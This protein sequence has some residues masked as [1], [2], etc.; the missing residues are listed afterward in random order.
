MGTSDD[1][2]LEL[3]PVLRSDSLQ[4]LLLGGRYALERALG[5]GGAG[6]VYRA[7][8]QPLGRAVAVKVLRTDLVPHA[9]EQ[10][11]ARFLRE[12]AAAGSLAHPNLVTV[13]DFGSEYGLHYVVM[14]L[15][16]GRTLLRCLKAEGPLP[17]PEVARVGAAVARG[18]RHAHQAGLVHRDIKPSNIM[19][20]PDD[21]EVEQPVLLD[22]GLVKMVTEASEV[23]RAGQFLGTPQYMAPEQVMG[24]A[25]ARSDVYALGVVLYELVTGVLPFDAETAL[26]QAVQHNTDAVPSM[27]V[28]AQDKVV[29]P[30]LEAI[31]VRA[32]NREPDARYVDAGDFAQALEDWRSAVLRAHTPL[33]PLPA[34]PSATRLG[35]WAL[36]ASVGAMGVALALVA[37]GL[38]GAI[39]GGMLADEPTPHPGYGLGA[40]TPLLEPTPPGSE[41]PAPLAEQE[42]ERVLVSERGA[43]PAR[44]DPSPPRPARAG[45]AAPPTPAPV[46]ASAPTPVPLAAVEEAS[47]HAS[48]DDVPFTEA[49]AEATMAWVN[50]ASPNALAEAGVWDRGVGVILDA[51]PFRDV[52]HLASTKW[53]GTKTVQA[54]KDA[55]AP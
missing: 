11:G 33:P 31:I 13:H 50:D 35:G 38:G 27:R 24:E 3:E 10:F 51:R 5:V 20:V 39:L 17:P 48:T 12:A 23:S 25:D 15:L 45:T 7:V 49:E 9:R 18:L 22:F 1:E 32:L 42:P 19:L 52:E 26:G 30:A 37:V 2:P 46:Q 34:P 41:D 54:C 28:R 43:A 29:P 6:H 14:E 47:P 44:P 8:Q 4:G 21:D 53:I 55:A 40:P 16:A 36:L